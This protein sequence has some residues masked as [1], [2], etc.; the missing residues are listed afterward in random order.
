MNTATEKAT[1]ILMQ[2]F[3][4]SYSQSRF[5]PDEEPMRVPARICPASYIVRYGGSREDMEAGKGNVRKILKRFRR[6]FAGGEPITSWR[7]YIGSH[8]RCSRGVIK[9][10]IAEGQ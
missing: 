10:R 2:Y 8:E 7:H 3:E 6:R 1:T 4:W 9:F 5:V